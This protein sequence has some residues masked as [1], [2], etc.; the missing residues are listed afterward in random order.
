MF[1]IFKKPEQSVPDVKSIRNGL[2][3]FIKTQLAKAEGGEGARIKSIQLYP[4]L[5]RRGTPPLRAR[6]VPG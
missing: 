2:L 5:Q 6:R 3:Q 4:N 1:D